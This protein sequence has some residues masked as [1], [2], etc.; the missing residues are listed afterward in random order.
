[1]HI[2]FFSVLTGVI[3]LLG[4]ILILHFCGFFK[5]FE[6]PGSDQSEED[7]AKKTVKKAL[8]TTSED[9]SDD[10]NISQDNDVI[11]ISKDC[12]L[13]VNPQHSSNMVYAAMMM[14]ANNSN[15]SSSGNT[16]AEIHGNYIYNKQ[17]KNYVYNKQTKNNNTGAY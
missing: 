8:T 13:L 7:Y 12:N 1:M 5:R 11:D 4:L 15:K 3:L 9:N 14:M 16:G 2:V 10:E 6:I 17:T